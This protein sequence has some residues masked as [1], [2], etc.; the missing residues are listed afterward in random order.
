MFPFVPIILGAV[1]GGGAV[2][3]ISVI[4]D[5]LIM[6]KVIRKTVKDES[7]S[8]PNAFKY[9]IKEAK[10]NA[11]KVGIFDPSGNE[12]KE[13]NIGSTQGV[14]EKVKIGQYEYC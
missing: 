7:L 13:I 11:V 1:L 2:F 4:I 12:L 8:I 3:A 5:K 6:R 9:K 14:D 10:K